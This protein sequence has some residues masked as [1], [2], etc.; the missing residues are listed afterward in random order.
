MS[1]KLADNRDSLNNRVEEL[2]AANERGKK[3]Q[4]AYYDHRTK[5]S[6]LATRTQTTVAQL[7]QTITERDQAIIE[8]D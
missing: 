4:E 5:L 1:G 6:E 3:W 8:R 2:K 7:N